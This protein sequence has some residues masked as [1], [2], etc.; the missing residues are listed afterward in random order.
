MAYAMRRHNARM[1]HN[2]FGM[3][4]L[5]NVLEDWTSMRYDLPLE[6]TAAVVHVQAVL[7]TSSILHKWKTQLAKYPDHRELYNHVRTELRDA[8]DLRDDIWEM[9]GYNVAS[10]DQGLYEA[11]EMRNRTFSCIHDFVTTA[12][13]SQ[14]AQGAADVV[15]IPRWDEPLQPKDGRNPPALAVSPSWD[16]HPIVMMNSTQMAAEEERRRREA[17]SQ[18]QPEAKARPTSHGGGASTPMGSAGASAKPPPKARP[19]QPPTP[20]DWVI[21]KTPNGYTFKTSTNP[22]H[23]GSLFMTSAWMNCLDQFLLSIM[24]GPAA[25]ATNITGWA[26]YLRRV[27][28]YGCMIFGVCNPAVVTDDDAAKISEADWLKCYSL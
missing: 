15:H 1:G 18:P 22:D 21:A 25:S 26:Q 6:R 3:I 20:P 12:S 9:G 11:I 7:M 16:P 14:I 19:T 8:L 2:T 4:I 27:S 24:Q 13:A 28:A 10:A 17:A 5:Q 23:R